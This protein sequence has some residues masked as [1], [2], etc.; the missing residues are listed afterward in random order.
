MDRSGLSEPAVW[1]CRSEDCC[2]ADSRLRLGQSEGSHPPCQLALHGYQVVPAFVRLSDV[3]HRPSFQVL[4][5]KN[6]IQHKPDARQRICLFWKKCQQVR[7]A[8]QA[9]RGCVA[10]LQEIGT[11]RLMFGT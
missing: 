11:A 7:E 10:A 5:R 6:K 1:R 8:F 9:V 4:E 2:K 3:L